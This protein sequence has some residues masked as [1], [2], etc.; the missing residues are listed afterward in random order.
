MP[1][2]STKIHTEVVTGTQIALATMA[3]LTA[4]GFALASVPVKKVAELK[5]MLNCSAT[6]TKTAGNCTLKNGQPGYKEFAY[7]CPNGKSYHT[8]G[9]CR[10]Q[11]SFLS[12][13]TQGCT[14]LKYCVAS[15]P[16]RPVSPP[17]AAVRPV[18][19]PVYGGYG[20]NQPAPSI[21]KYYNPAPVSSNFSDIAFVGRPEENITFEKYGTQGPLIKVHVTNRGPAALPASE[22]VDGGTRITLAFMNEKQ[23]QVSVEKNL[24]TSELP[25]IASGQPF[26]KTFEITPAT[27]NA[28]RKGDIKFVKVEVTI[29]NRIA[30]N[31]GIFDPD[32]M[33][34][35][36]IM[37]V[38]DSFIQL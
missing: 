37:G 29:G 3:L 5:P 15:V 16:A 24:F 18:V 30:G 4:G 25:E 14:R 28:M 1:R 36:L 27:Y 31:T 7:T 38:P 13:A 19:P 11:E 9:I 2:A 6:L 34:N 17:L 26:D 12:N 35:I 8:V 22:K 32:I 33:N 10:T 20:Y 23:E 21:I